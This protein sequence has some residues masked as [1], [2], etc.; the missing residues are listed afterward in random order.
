MSLQETQGIMS[1]QR[2]ELDEEFM[3]ITEEENETKPLKQQQE[4]QLEPIVSILNLV[5]DFV[6]TDP[7]PLEPDEFRWKLMNNKHQ[8]GLLNEHNC[9][10]QEKDESQQ[11]LE[12]IQVPVIRIF[13]PIIR[14]AGMSSSFLSKAK[15]QSQGETSLNVD[16]DRKE[17]EVQ[18][19]LDGSGNNNEN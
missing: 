8:S 1:Q 11:L 18:T 6:M 10:E 15:D 2:L 3:S 16:H 14:G 17:P 7:S 13:G 4:Q 19:G 9:D 12:E 5:V